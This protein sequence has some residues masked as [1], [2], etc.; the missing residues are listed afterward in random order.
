MFVGIFG[1]RNPKFGPTRRDYQTHIRQCVR[2]SLFD[3]AHN[4]ITAIGYGVACS[5][6]CSS[7]KF[8]CYKE[9][10]ADP[11]T[12]SER[13][14][15]IVVHG[16]FKWTAPCDSDNNELC[17]SPPALV[18]V[19]SLAQSIWGG[20]SIKEILSHLR[21]EFSLLVVDSRS[22]LLNWW[23]STD[24]YGTTPLVFGWEPLLSRVFVSCT[25]QSISAFTE[26]VCD[27]PA[28]HYLS[29]LSPDLPT[30]WYIDFIE[31]PL[32]TTT[33]ATQI[34]INVLNALITSV[35]VHLNR[36]PETN[37]IYVIN[38]SNLTS[39]FL[40]SIIQLLIKNG[41]YC[42]VNINSQNAPIRQMLLR[43]VARP[44]EKA[45]SIIPFDY[46]VSQLMY[47]IN[48]VPVVN[49]VNNVSD[50]NDLSHNSIIGCKNQD[51]N[52]VAC[53]SILDAT[54]LVK[55][56][57]GEQHRISSSNH[58]PC[59]QITHEFTIDDGITAVI[60]VM[61]FVNGRF[62]EVCDFVPFWIMLNEIRLK[63][64]APRHSENGHNAD[65]SSTR[66]F[67][68][69]TI[70]RNFYLDNRTPPLSIKIIKQIATSMGIVVEFPLI[71]MRLNESLMRTQMTI[72][73][74]VVLNWLEKT[75]LRA[76]YSELPDSSHNEPT[77]H[78]FFSWKQELRKY[79]LQEMSSEKFIS[80]QAEYS[81]NNTP[82]PNTRE[83]AW[84]LQI[85][86]KS[87]EQVTQANR[88]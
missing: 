57:P 52:I 9:R 63:H 47:S 29:S 6:S 80:M 82:A 73:Q 41:Y 32:S 4:I 31:R 26:K 50:M 59:A 67:M 22:C 14:V 68:P 33:C 79:A 72:T 86:S 38:L 17:K 54:T 34:N 19:N 21:G 1:T 88:V 16:F 62:D 18:S 45:P 76:E 60:D 24:A 48:S 36:I 69:L 84:L 44:C 42:P 71:D 58:I 78:I 15:L 51:E 35:Q 61:R 11:N 27:I 70:L 23:A 87:I 65:I 56:L 53:D 49:A 13:S 46:I 20:A 77:D 85:Y 2:C 64:C 37:N 12:I 39:I 30:Q 74:S 66:V 7:C 8:Y 75:P 10:D 83:D 3:G 43:F 5:V 55:A 25:K 40:W 28:G 81:S